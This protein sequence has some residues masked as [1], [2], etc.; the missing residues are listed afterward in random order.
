MPTVKDI[1]VR[2]ATEQ[3]K[4]NCSNWPIWSSQ[5]SEFDWEYTQKETCLIIEGKAIV[6]DPN[7]PQEKVTFE[8][9]DL[10][11]FP[12]ELSCRWII[13]EAIKKYYNFE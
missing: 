7:D 2:K 9:G 5:P 1:I 11:I 6:T 3:D 8:N 10:V 13:T 4:I 12:N